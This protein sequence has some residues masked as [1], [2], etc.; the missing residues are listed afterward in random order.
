MSD[1]SSFT[2]QDL[3]RQRERIR[4]S[5]LRANTAVA[6]VLVGVLALATAAILASLRSS[7]EQT[8]AELAERDARDRLWNAYLSQA[9]ASRLSGKRGRRDQSIQVLSNAATIR[10]SPQLRSE[11]VAA[12]TTTD[13]EP[14]GPVHP[15]NIPFR[16]VFEPGLARYA[17]ADSLGVIDVHRTAD[18]TQVFRVPLADAGQ[19]ADTPLADLAFTHDHRFLAIVLRNGAVAACELNSRTVRLV[20]PPAPDRRIMGI[21]FGRDGWICLAEQGS[22]GSEVTL[23]EVATGTLRSHGFTRELHGAS[24]RPGSTQLAVAFANEVVLWDEP[25]H[26]TVASFTHTGIVGVP[27]WSSDGARFATAA[28][29]GTIHLWTV[30]GARSRILPGHSEYVTGLAF[31]PDNNFLLSRALDNS[32][33]LWDAVAGRLI[34]ASDSTQGTGFSDDG[35]RIGFSQLGQGV[36]IWRIRR[37][38]AVRHLQPPGTTNSLLRHVDLSLDG[39]LLAAVVDGNLYLHDLDTPS[40]FSSTGITNATAATFF[41]DNRSILVART[42]R[43]EARPI[44]PGPA[45]SSPELGPPTVVPA[46]PTLVPRQATLSGDGRSALV[47]WTDLTL[48]VLDLGGQ[49]PPVRLD[50]HSWNANALT[51]G[52]PT[53]SGRFAIS[54]DGRWAAVGYG[55]GIEGPARGASNAHRGAVWDARTGRRV[56]QLPESGGVL[57]SPDGL[58]LLVRSARAVH[59]YSVG[60]FDPVREIPLDGLGTHVGALCMLPDAS[61]L[62]AS[63]TRQSVIVVHPQTGQEWATLTPP[64]PVSINRLRWAANGRRLVFTTTDQQILLWD[65]PALRTQLHAMGLSDTDSALPPVRSHADLRFPVIASGLA[66]AALAV[67]SGLVVLRRHRQLVQQFVRTEATVEQRN[68]QLEQARIE[69]LQADKMKALGTLA[70]GIAHDFNNLLSVIRMSNQLIPRARSRDE[71]TE[72]VDAVEQAVLQGKTVVGSMLGYSRDGSAVACA[73]DV[74]QVIRD[75]SLLL[76]REFLAGIE[77]RHELRPALPPVHISPGKLQ[78]ILLNLIVNAAEAMKGSGTL[79]LGAQA[80]DILPADAA[81]RYVVRPR[82]SPTYIR[83]SIRD[84][85]PGIPPEILDRIFEPFFT[86]KS[87]GTRKGTGLGLSMVHTVAVHAGLGL[88]VSSQPGHGATFLLFLPTGPDPAASSGPCAPNTHSTQASPTPPSP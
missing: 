35:Q 79:L 25:T 48:S 86:T 65:L 64:H 84:T 39:R 1:T 63:Q 82:D 66:A 45:G 70:A 47:E 62:A 43:L 53:G 41:P 14:D 75:T 68:L 60:S 37:G 80:I 34:V 11:A 26:S 83:V 56:F 28:Y 2:R 50:G 9:Q 23:V 7:R 72:Y 10:M 29:N 55:V 8:R 59:V 76:S 30:E 32:T 20:R 27:E 81:L 40:P 6:L 38:D 78:Q 69:L 67:V 71:V 73:I 33:R 77:L 16:Q 42:D 58:E 57:F 22:A 88:A 3:D 31:S 44:R 15:V 4:R 61:L 12:L 13:L 85:G 36:G 19:P 5:F 49:R 51:P 87:A 46:H 18:H 17:L 54:P 21:S 74:P 24:R 52:T